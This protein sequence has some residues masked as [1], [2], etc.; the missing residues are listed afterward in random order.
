M[1]S[2]QLEL[3]ESGVTAPEMPSTASTIGPRLRLILDAIEALSAPEREAFELV[4]H[5]RD[6]TRGN[7]RRYRGIRQ[8]GST[9]AE[10]V[11]GVAKCGPSESNPD[12]PTE[13]RGCQRQ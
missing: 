11:V 6:D 1:T 7:G 13:C 10:P 5:P 3:R 2:A 12:C 9:T 4:S 8:D